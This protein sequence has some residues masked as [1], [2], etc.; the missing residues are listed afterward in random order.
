MSLQ[1]RGMFCSMK[2]R[3]EEE[4]KFAL[5][6]FPTSGCGTREAFYF[7]I[8]FIFQVINVSAWKI[9]TNFQIK[10]LGDVSRLIHN[11]GNSCRNRNHVFSLRLQK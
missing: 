4:E 8:L 7:F 6:E 2:F 5:P 1:L 9:T 3:D 11:F 10:K